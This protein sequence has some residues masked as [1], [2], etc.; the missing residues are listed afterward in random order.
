MPRP[1]THIRVNGHIYRR[2]NV[3][4]AAGLRAFDTLVKVWLDDGYRELFEKSFAHLPVEELALKMAD[5][6][7][8]YVG[9]LAEDNVPW[10]QYAKQIKGE[11]ER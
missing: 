11:K 5:K 1:P 6:F 7:G 9:S 8:A 4:D 3:L 2:A 10:R